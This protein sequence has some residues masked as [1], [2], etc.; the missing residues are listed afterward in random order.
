MLSGEH[1]ISHTCQ[2]FKV[3]YPID[4]DAT[5]QFLKCLKCNQEFGVLIY[6]HL[7][8]I[9]MRRI[10]YANTDKCKGG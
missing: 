10:Q 2:K 3:K 4:G 9:Q 1:W 5:R 8:G 7:W 6:S